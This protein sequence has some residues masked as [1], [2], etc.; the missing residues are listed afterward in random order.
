MN[1]RKLPIGLLVLAHVLMALVLVAA[2]WRGRLSGTVSIGLGA[3]H[4]SQI[5]LLGI[6]LALGLLAGPW[7]LLCVLGDVVA[8]SDAFFRLMSSLGGIAGSPGREMWI[9]PFAAHVAIT[10][11]PLLIARAAG[12]R[13]ICIGGASSNALPSGQPRRFQ[14]SIGYLLAWTT[15]V[16]VVLSTLQYL[17][18]FKGL[19]Y[20]LYFYAWTYL[21]FC[22]LYTALAIG[23]L[24]LVFGTWPLPGRILAFILVGVLATGSH[25]WLDRGDLDQSLFRVLAFYAIEAALLLGSLAVVRIAGYRLRWHRRPAVSEPG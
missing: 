12:M 17:T 11:L 5:G 21:A 1:S 15:V 10:A 14:F 4:F 8:W 9:W 22:G 6:W 25:C 23:A 7:R 2:A 13:M 24:W 3:V 18:A 16:A 19:E 20:M